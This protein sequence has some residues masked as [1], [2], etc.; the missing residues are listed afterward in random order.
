MSVQQLLIGFDYFK[1]ENCRSKGDHND[2]D[3]LIVTISNDKI[4]QPPQKVLLG[5]NLHQGDEVRGA[6]VGPFL[7]DSNAHVIVS[8]VVL[9]SADGDVVDNTAA[10]VATALGVVLDGF[11]FG[12]GIGGVSKAPF[13]GI[14]PTKI[15]ELILGAAGIVF[16]IVGAVLGNSN[17][18]CSGAVVV[19]NFAFD[20]G[21]KI[22]LPTGQVEE[23]QTSPHECGNNPNSIVSYGIQSAASVAIPSGAHAVARTPDHLDI[24]WV[25][26]NRGIGST[27]WDAAPGFGWA[28]HQPFPI[29]PSGA[30]QPSS[31][32]AVVARTP[33]HLDVFW[34]GPDGGIGSTFWDATLGLGW[35]D[36]RPFPITPPGAAQP[37]SRVAAVA[38]TPNHLDVF[39]VGPDGGIGSTFWDAA[40]GF[41]WGDHQPFAIA[42]PGAAQRGS[43]L[44]VVAR[45]P[46]HLDVFWVGPDGGI[47][48]TFWDVAP[49][50]GWGDHQPFPIAPPSAAQ[51][52]SRVAAVARNANHL[53]VF[54]VGPDGG[55][56]STFWD[57]APGFGW[58]DHQPFPIAPPGAAQPGSGLAVVARTPSHLD[59]FWVGPDGAIGSTFWDAAA[60]FGWGDHQPF[61]ITPPGAAQPGSWVAA[62]A[63]TANHLDVF[64][65]GPDGGIGSTFWDAASGFGWGDH[66][67]F[68]IASSGAAALR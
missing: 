5:N 8:F 38:R 19:R 33:S 25:G 59:V 62:V 6:L 22:T 4:V 47:G 3:T 1:V 61:P 41:G 40:P 14:V 7:M 66:Q 18:D 67:P 21:Q 31:Q 58:A 30:A 23:T 63:R 64:W 27:F 2:V 28:D 60:G 42:P 9:N 36:H 10:K 55:I 16:D 24:F 46:D 53:D 20:P 12:I 65:V 45:S 54:W 49:G 39:W 50:L 34:V 56:G 68:P 29:A 37:G 52:A 26:P 44:A 15:D 48:S 43:G 51:A 11:D 17:P 35:G 13:L 57:A 32:V